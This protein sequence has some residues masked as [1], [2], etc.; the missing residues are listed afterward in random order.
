M[1]LRELVIVAL[2]ICIL[3]AVIISCI[4]MHKCQSEGGLV[5]RGVFGLEC[6][7][8]EIAAKP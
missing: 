4:D 3:V 7:K 6:I 5:V 8:T 2:I 1:K